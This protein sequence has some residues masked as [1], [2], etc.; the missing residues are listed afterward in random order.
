[1]SRTCCVGCARPRHTCLIRCLAIA[2]WQTTRGRSIVNG[3]KTMCVHLECAK[4]ISLH[5]RIC[6]PDWLIVRESRTIVQHQVTI[7]LQY[8]IIVCILRYWLWLRAFP[9]VR[10]FMALPPFNIE[11]VITNTRRRFTH[12]DIMMLSSP[13]HRA[14][15]F[16][17]NPRL[18]SNTLELKIQH[19]VFP[20]TF[21]TEIY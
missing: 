3:Q 14:I 17:S 13:L 6:T 10:M 12:C 20:L 9:A 1:M 18:K 19:L 5:A 8:Q 15:V 2:L 4:M 21:D 11:I 16:S 7:I